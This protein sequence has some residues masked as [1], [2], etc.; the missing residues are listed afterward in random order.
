MGYRLGPLRA[1]YDCKCNSCEH[2]WKV[3][4]YLT[5][6]LGDLEKCENCRSRNIIIKQVGSAV[7]L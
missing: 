2:T 1:S 6:T 5:E 7:R 4:A 3:S